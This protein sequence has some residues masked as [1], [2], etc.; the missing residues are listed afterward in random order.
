MRHGCT[1]GATRRESPC[2]AT[3]RIDHRMPPPGRR[4]CPY[5]ISDVGSFLIVTRR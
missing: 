4:H 1:V 2:A 3:P 5:L